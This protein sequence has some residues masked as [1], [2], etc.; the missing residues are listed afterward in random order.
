MIYKVLNEFFS[1]DFKFGPLFFPSEALLQIC[2]LLI[3]EAANQVPAGFFFTLNLPRFCFRQR[4]ATKQLRK[5]FGYALT[6][7][8]SVL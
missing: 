2:N 4:E 1:R 8:D 5:S 3:F 7:Y 6:S